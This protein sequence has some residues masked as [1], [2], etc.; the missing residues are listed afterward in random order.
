[1][2]L[3]SF[4]GTGRYEE[5]IYRFGESSYRTRYLTRALAEFV[6]PGEIFSIAT[7]E[8]WGTHGTALEQELSEGGHPIP[9]RVAVPSEG[10]PQS[11][12]R[13]FQAIVETIRTSQCPV[14]LDIT[15]GFRMQPFLAGA[16]VQYAQSV[17]ENPPEIR[18]VYGEYRGSGSES[19]VWELTPFVEILSWSRDLMMFLQTGRAEEVAR[20]AEELDRQ[21]RREWSGGGRQG[22]E[23]RLGQLATSLRNFGGGLATIRTGALLV[24]ENSSAQRLF[25]A[26]D[27][28]RGEVEAHLPALG[29]VLDQV[30]A[31]VEP[32]RT[33]GARLSSRAGQRA[34]WALADLYRRMGRYSESI[35]IVREGWMTL[36]APSGVDQPGPCEFNDDQ[37]REL[38][39]SRSEEFRNDRHHPFHR[40]VQMRNDIQ[41]AGFRR[42]PM[43]RDSFDEGLEH[44]LLCWREAID[45]MERG[46]SE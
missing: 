42:T 19:P 39:R 23:P 43:R 34:L 46:D 2:R 5:A 36:G 38:E 18:V 8:A 20:R 21:R 9:N 4:L 26:I 6:N 33:D 3:I 24:G 44:C 37:R 32:L 29:M 40:V 13:M 14:L 11:L 7:E 25:D 27:R 41:H 17:L 12:W 35:S 31:M 16:C 28:A 45:S 30:R 1:M 15:H 10:D 22:V